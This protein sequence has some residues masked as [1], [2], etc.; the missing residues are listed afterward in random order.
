M[1]SAFFFLWGAVIL[2]ITASK[3]GI[4]SSVRPYANIGL[5]TKC[6]KW[7]GEIHINCILSVRYALQDNYFMTVLVTVVVLSWNKRWF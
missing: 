1:L 6:E 5:I 4:I 2:Y 7:K 3:N